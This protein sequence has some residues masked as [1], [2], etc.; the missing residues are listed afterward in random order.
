[1][2]LAVPEA[3]TLPAADRFLAAVQRALDDGVA[4]V[5]RDSAS[6]PEV[7]TFLSRHRALGDY[8]SV[9][10]IVARPDRSPAQSIAE[11]FGAVPSLA[12]LT[13]SALDQTLAIVDLSALPDADCD[14]WTT[15]VERMTARRAEHTG[16]VGIVLTDAPPVLT[17]RTGHPGQCWGDHL[18]RV[19]LV[20]WADRHVPSTAPA[21]HGNM[22]ATLA[23]ELC[24]WRLDLAEQIAQASI[25]D[26]ADPLGWLDR[27]EAAAIPDRAIPVDGRSARCPLSLTADGKAELRGR[28]WRAQL[29]TFYPW[30]EEQRQDFV[31]L[32]RRHLKVDEHLRALGVEDVDGI[33]IGA[34]AFQLRDRVGR[35]DSDRLAMLKRMRNALAHRQPAD[36]ADVATALRPA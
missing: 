18:R 21:L 1:M 5:G 31:A 7:S 13:G 25:D 12:A 2:T 8:P 9:E 4:I 11:P 28:I 19:D 20:I 26:L 17:K 34:L 14:D 15:F 33:E 22:A 30:L 35:M 16:G 3:W 6:P 10:R 36:P 29:M 27:R 23:V 32:H 24:G